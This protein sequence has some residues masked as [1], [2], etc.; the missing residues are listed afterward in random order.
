MKDFFSDL[1]ESLSSNR[2]ERTVVFSGKVNRFDG[3]IIQCD[4][5]PAHVGT[6]CRVQISG[7]E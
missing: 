7:N 1:S 4:G 2:Y 3:N 6:L 5:F